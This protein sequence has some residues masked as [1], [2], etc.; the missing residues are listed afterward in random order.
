MD[1]AVFVL[2][3]AIVDINFIGLF[4]NI[5]LRHPW[6]VT[7]KERIIF[8]IHVNDIKSNCFSE[9][10]EKIT[11]THSYTYFDSHVILTKSHLLLGKRFFTYHYKVCLK[12]ID[13]I[14][15]EVA[16]KWR[17]K[18]KLLMVSET[19]NC[20][21]LITYHALT[22]NT[23]SRFY[24]LIRELEAARCNVLASTL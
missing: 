8:S 13:S 22:K 7:I 17:H 4:S 12:D 21:L 24:R 6:L 15:H 11:I 1:A 20:E 14:K 10:K 9:D 23:H 19:G 3:F 5:F 18:L 2:L 16:L